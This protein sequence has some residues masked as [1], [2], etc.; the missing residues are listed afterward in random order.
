MG[1]FGERLRREREMRGISLDEMATATK[2]STRNLKALEEEKFGQ[3]PGGIF[4]KGFVRAYAKFLGIDE[5]QMVAEYVTASQDT[6]AARDQKL[7]ADLSK[8]QF[9][10]PLENEREI[11]LEPKSQWGTIAVIVL[12]AV[13]GFGGY[14]V[15]QKRKAERLA[16]LASRMGLLNHDQILELHQSVLAAGMVAP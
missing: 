7:Q 10:R 8:I 5:D 6:D 16:K 2:I 14:Q 12:L 15:Y 1:S 13:G 4:N 9:K 11:S 3:L